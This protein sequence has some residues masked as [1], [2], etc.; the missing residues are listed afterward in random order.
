MNAEQLCA[1]WQEA[2][3]REEQAKADRLA[4]E[5]LLVQQLGKKDEG[6]QTHELPGLKVTITGKMTR[7]MDWTA[8]GLVRDQIPA[9]MHPV[10]T[11]QE[12]D[13]T[14]VKWLQANHP[15]FYKLLPI[16]VKPAKPSIAIKAVAVATVEGAAA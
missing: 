13:E 9:E 4:V 16:E 10:R 12:L 8:W 6:A 14:G 15:D 11:K 3:A 7:T 2:K 1:K 5:E